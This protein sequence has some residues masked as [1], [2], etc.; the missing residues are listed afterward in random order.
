MPHLPLS[1]E[2]RV[3]IDL[4]D[5]DPD[6]DQITPL[7]PITSN[8]SAFVIEFV[9]GFFHDHLTPTMAK[10]IDCL[11]L[12][13]LELLEIN[14][15][16]HPRLAVC[17][18]HITSSVASLHAPDSIHLRA[19]DLSQVR[20][21]ILEHAVGPDE[22]EQSLCLV[23]RLRFFSAQSMLKFNDVLCLEFLLS[24]LQDDEFE[25]EI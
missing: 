5:P 8:I 16:K 21:A 15:E 4:C 2:F 10:I 14:S 1:A 11:T 20:L 3:R 6:W 13:A 9:D 19:L 18:G 17:L 23:P 7:P 24:R 12:L 22:T 25:M